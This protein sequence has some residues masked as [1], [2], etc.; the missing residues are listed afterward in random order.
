MKGR[1][2][3]VLAV[4]FFSTLHL[5]LSAFA[6]RTAFTYQGQLNDNGAQEAGM[7]SSPLISGFSM[8]LVKLMSSL[9][10]VTWTLTVST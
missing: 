6:Q 8:L 2:F 7:I 1:L 5:Q 9:P 4:T 3:A 10:S